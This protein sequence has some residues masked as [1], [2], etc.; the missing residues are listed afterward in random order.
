MDDHSSVELAGCRHSDGRM[1][2]DLFRGSQA[3]V[4]RARAHVRRTHRGWHDTKRSG[5]ARGSWPNGVQ[6]SPRC[7]SGRVF[8]GCCRRDPVRVDA[9]VDSNTDRPGAGK[10]NRG[11]LYAYPRLRGWRNRRLTGYYPKPFLNPSENPIWCESLCLPSCWLPLPLPLSNP[12]I[13]PSR[14]SCAVPSSTDAFLRMSDGVPTASGSTS[15]GSSPAPTG[16][17][18]QSGIA[19][20]PFQGQSRREW[21]LRSSILRERLSRQAIDRG[22]VDTWLS[23]MVETSM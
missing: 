6:W 4:S 18:R 2:E 9:N 23:N 3:G 5:F 1:D 19:F 17:R 15:T 16:A 8:H 10:F 12:S 7:G 11:A 20:A 21:R 22:T 14:T 13:S